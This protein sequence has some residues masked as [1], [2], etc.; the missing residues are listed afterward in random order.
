M[1]HDDHDAVHHE[2]EGLDA[3]E[4]EFAAAIPRRSAS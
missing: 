3:R 1:N 2:H 4:L